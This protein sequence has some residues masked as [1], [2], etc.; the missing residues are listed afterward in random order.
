MDA[1]LTNVSVNA[2]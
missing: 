2:H 1:E